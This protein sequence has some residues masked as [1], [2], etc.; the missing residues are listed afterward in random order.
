[1]ENKASYVNCQIAAYVTTSEK[2]QETYVYVNLDLYWVNITEDILY[3]Y[4]SL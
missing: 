1:M 3:N 4:V 2:D